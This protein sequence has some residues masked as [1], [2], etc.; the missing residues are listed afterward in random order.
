MSE[1]ISDVPPL[2]HITQATQVVLDIE[3][4]EL[5]CGLRRSEIF[6][7]ML[8]DLTPDDYDT[9]LKLDERVL[10][11]TAGSL[12]SGIS[13]KPSE[14]LPPGLACGICLVAFSGL[15][16]KSTLVK[17]LDRCGHTFHADCI[18]RWLSSYSH[19]CPVDNLSLVS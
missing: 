2:Q 19:R 18:D 17:T 6:S 8:R 10:K 7:L 3:D 5:P 11:K 9:L 4:Y 16:D 14:C 15:A 1:D 12:V 13:S